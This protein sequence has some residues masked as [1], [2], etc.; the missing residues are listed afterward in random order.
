MTRIAIA[1]VLS[2]VYHIRQPGFGRSTPLY[3]RFRARVSKIVAAERMALHLRLRCLA[4]QPRSPP[5]RGCRAR[6]LFV[7]SSSRAKRRTRQRR[8]KQRYPWC[9][10][11]GGSF[12][13]ASAID[14]PKS[15][16][17]EIRQ[18][19]Q[20]FRQRARRSH[21]SARIHPPFGKVR[22]EAIGA[23]VRER[24]CDRRA[25]LSL[26]HLECCFRLDEARCVFKVA[27]ACR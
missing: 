9:V 15:I 8:M 12:E 5:T 6:W 22:A 24:A 21:R 27:S 23:R 10:H 11:R 14:L 18:L 16:V 3:E 13:Q 1:R 25:Y 4:S 19:L 7:E 20:W 2:I 17:S 26:D